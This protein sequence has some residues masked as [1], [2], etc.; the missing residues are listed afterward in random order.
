MLASAAAGT[1]SDAGSQ[2][3]ERG[4]AQLSW[5][6]TGMRRADFQSRARS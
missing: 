3:V 4:A 2:S 6:F 5:S 1:G